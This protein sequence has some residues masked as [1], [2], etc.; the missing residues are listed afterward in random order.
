MHG[1]NHCVSRI[2]TF[3]LSSFNELK[4]TWGDFSNFLVGRARKRDKGTHFKRLSKVFGYFKTEE[5]QAYIN[6]QFLTPGNVLLLTA[7]S[8]R[9][10]E[11][12]GYY[13]TERNQ[14]YVNNQLLTSIL[15]L[16]F[17]QN[18]NQNEL[19]VLH[20]TYLKTNIYI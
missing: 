16:L 9:L 12:L 13:V 7:I 17:F 18:K 2:C 4:L 19:W 20:L 3:C 14:A 8:K 6:T 1:I 11:V 5:N 15:K 10:S